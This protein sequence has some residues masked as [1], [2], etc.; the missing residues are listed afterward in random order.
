M[1][2]EAKEATSQRMYNQWCKADCAVEREILH[3][4]RA[5]LDDLVFDLVAE[6]R[7]TYK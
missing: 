1:V 5:A 4:K 2:T 3:H 7:K 6:L